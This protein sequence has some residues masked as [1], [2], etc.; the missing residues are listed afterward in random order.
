MLRDPFKGIGVWTGF[1]LP[2]GARAMR[3]IDQNRSKSMSNQAT[4]VV[5]HVFPFQSRPGQKPHRCTSHG[6]MNKV[7][8][9]EKDKIWWNKNRTYRIIC[10]T[11]MIKYVRYL[12][13]RC[14]SGQTL[15][16][17]WPGAELAGP[18]TGMA[19]RL[20]TAA[21]EPVFPLAKAKAKNKLKHKKPKFEES[22][23]ID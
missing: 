7:M 16:S 19:S 13:R 9:N 20:R 4:S 18:S 17:S 8:Q 14:Q 11:Y 12:L 10:R 6:R 5:F 23:R 15:P 22:V 3:R 1:L 21:R 2:K